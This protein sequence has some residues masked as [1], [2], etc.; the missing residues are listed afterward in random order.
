MTFRRERRA[1]AVNKDNLIGTPGNSRLRAAPGQ[2]INL[3]IGIRI[4]QR[5]Q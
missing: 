2:R 4:P 3:S 1:Q 5:R